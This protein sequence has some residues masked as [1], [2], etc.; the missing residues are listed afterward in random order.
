M[1]FTGDWIQILGVFATNKNMKG[2]I[3]AK[4]LIEAVIHAENAGLSVDCITGDGA[5]WNR[6]MWSICGIGES[7]SGQI[8]YKVHHPC[9]GDSDRSL[10]FLSDFP[11]L[12]KCVRNA[13]LKTGF[14]TS[15]GEIRSEFLKAAWK[16]DSE[17]SMALKV[18]P[19]ITNVH[20]H[21]NNFKKN[22]SELCVSA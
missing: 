20:F 11:H 5:S 19:K 15:M 4:T 3:L 22:E 17:M 6:S 7:S 1:P 12:V 2:D 21:P 16:K 8:N 18:M 14:L 9:G 13:F 10:L